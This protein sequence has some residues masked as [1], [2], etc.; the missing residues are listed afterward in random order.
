MKILVYQPRVSYFLG[1]GEVYPLQAIKFFCKDG[2]DV[3][4]LTTKAKFLKQS[5]YFKEFLK[6]TPN[7]KVEYLELDDNFKS[8]YDVPAG[9]DWTRWDRESLWV[10]RLAYQYI[11]K[12]D[13]DIIAIHNV[14]D[15]LAVPFGKKHILQLHGAPKEINYICQLILERENKLIAVSKNVADKWIGFG[16]SP[17]MVI[18]TNAIDGTIFYPR[19]D[20]ERD[21]DLLFVGRLIPIKG[22]QTILK[23]LKI[24]KSFFKPITL[25]PL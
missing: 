21:I 11:D 8:I 23:A 6:N 10:S 5:D 22:V 16:A 19:D 9:S 17:N 15:T 14:M 4:L 13:F 1:G 2:H 3:T 24:L 18:S 12:H 25:T 20:L 7:L